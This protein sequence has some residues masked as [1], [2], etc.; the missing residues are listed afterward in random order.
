MGCDS[1][2]QYERGFW[3]WDKKGKTAWA[4]VAPIGKWKKK[5][6]WAVKNI[7][8]GGCLLGKKRVLIRGF[9]RLW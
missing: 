8:T 6:V 1:K 5:R 3:E 9:P 2:K 4:D 7:K